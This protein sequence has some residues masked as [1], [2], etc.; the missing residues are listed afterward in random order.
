MGRFS[1]PSLFRVAGLCCSRWRVHATAVARSPY[2]PT[3]GEWDD[4]LGGRWRKFLK[5]LARRRRR[6]E[7]LAT[8]GVEVHATGEG[9]DA[10]L[11]EFVALEAS[12]W[13]AAEGTAVVSRSESIGFYAQIAAWAASHGW[14]RIWFLR[15]EGR[16]IA[17]E[18]ALEGGGA[19]YPLKS[20]FDP[21]YGRYSPG[22][23]LTYEA[24]FPPKQ[25]PTFQSRESTRMA[26]LPLLP[27]AG[28]SV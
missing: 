3:D 11:E 19:H 15:H 6:L 13:K 28:S 26:E 12:A 25:Q 23:L 9:L 20:G 21:A 27:V 2:V 1:H 16:A 24:A 10:A 4:Y 8:V 17:T 18:F 14:L 7:E 22:Q 5:D